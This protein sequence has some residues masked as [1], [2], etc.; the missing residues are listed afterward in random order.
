LVAQDY[1]DLSILV[2]ANGDSSE[3]ASRVAAIA[4][5]AFVKI[6][7]E[8]DGYAA[9]VNN[10]IGTVQGAAF[11]L[12][13]HD[14]VRLRPTA[15]RSLVEAAYRTNAAIVSPKFVGYEDESALVH[16]GQ[17]L[18]RFGAV[19]ER[20]EEGEI[21]AG[22]HDAERD[23]FV[24]PGGVTLVRADLFES[25][26]GYNEAI[27]LIGEDVDFCWRAQIAG[28]RVIV[29]PEAVVAHRQ[30]LTSGRRAATATLN[31]CPLPSR[32]ATWCVSSASRPC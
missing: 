27:N 19:V 14:D 1:E 26:G 2:L 13:C 29:A 18:D 30:S 7:P 8:N 12:L 5:L 28:A 25:L 23:V 4:P 21:D 16:V 32:F 20:I 31:P 22:Q 10:V 24:A 15:T 9:A 17:M 11:L 3:V 6:L